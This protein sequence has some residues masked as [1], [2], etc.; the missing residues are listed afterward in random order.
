MKLFEQKFFKRSGDWQACG[1]TTCLCLDDVCELWE[2]PE[3]VEEIWVSL[4]DCP[5]SDRYETEI[6]YWG[7]CISEVEV[8]VLSYACPLRSLSSKVLR[9]AN[10][11]AYTQVEYME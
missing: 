7:D 5:A 9:W 8:C 2:I 10:C 1:E 6:A 3:E 4:H 11:L